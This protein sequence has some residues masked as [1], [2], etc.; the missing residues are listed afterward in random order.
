M[1]V[2]AIVNPANNHT[3]LGGKRLDRAIQS[4]A[5]PK[6]AEE[7]RP[8]GGSEIGDVKIAGGHRLKGHHTVHMVALLYRDG[9]SGDSQILESC[10]RRFF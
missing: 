5:G 9:Q 7:C 8:I 10:N 2:D 4:A 1:D 3:L 6:L